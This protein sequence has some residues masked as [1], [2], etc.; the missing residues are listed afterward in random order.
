MQDKKENETDVEYKETEILEHFDKIF[1]TETVKNLKYFDFKQMKL[2]AKFYEYFEDEIYRPSIRY[3]H[4]Q[5][6]QNKI[7]DELEKQL[8]NE[9]MI[10]L[11]R[12]WEMTNDMASE[13]QQ[14]A[15][16]FGFIVAKEFDIE[17]KIK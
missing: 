16:M 4:L 5:R 17:C 9:Q 12:Y 14:Q 7:Y 8:T 11:E 3:K 10:L 13:E 15:F 6:E 1:E 2:L